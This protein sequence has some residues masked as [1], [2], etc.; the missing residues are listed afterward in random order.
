MTPLR[1]PREPVD[2]SNGSA[3]D[4]ARALRS[5]SLLEVR[6]IISGY[7]DLQVLRGVSLSA[8]QGQVELVLGR[9]G[10]GKTTLLSA[11]AG[12][13]PIWEGTLQIDGEDISRFPAHRRQAM[14]ISLVLEGK[15]IFRKRTVYENLLIGCHGQR[16]RRRAVV[17]KVDEMVSQLSL[18]KP[19]LHRV[20]GGLSGGQ[21]QI[22]A[23]GQALMANPKVLLLD[24]PSAGLS[25]A[26]VDEVL[27]IVTD[28]AQKGQCVVLVEQIVERIVGV[29]DHVVVI[30]DGQVVVEGGPEITNDLEVLREAYFG[31]VTG[32]GNEDHEIVR[33]AS[34]GARE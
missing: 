2:S 21:Q 7:R 5:P 16:I 26:M 34:P 17:K 22:L 11:I 24:E 19:V 10:A 20:A 6:S 13:L 33:G 32:P 12:I 28:L 4:D 29:A 1:S 18:L 3:R 14:G 23:I 25:P 8:Q 9:N 27:G 30:D 15:R 31:R